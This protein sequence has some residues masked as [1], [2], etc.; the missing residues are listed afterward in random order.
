MHVTGSSGC[1]WKILALFILVPLVELWLLLSLARHTSI[2]TALLV[3]LV[4]GVAGTLLVKAQGWRTMRRI[5]A[6]L[7]Q[8]RLPTDALLDASLIFAAG[9][10]LLTPGLLTDVVGISL[11]IPVCRRY[12]RRAVATW[13]QKHTRVASWT[14]TAPNARSEIVDAYVINAPDDERPPRQ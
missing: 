11:L 6:E 9:V 3:V 10:L 13:I 12:Y 4:M 2:W 8:G 1:L 7:Q 5:T 14:G